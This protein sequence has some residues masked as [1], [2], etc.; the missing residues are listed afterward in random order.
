MSFSVMQEGGYGLTGAELRRGGRPPDT[1][2]FATHRKERCDAEDRAE[3]RAAS[4]Q[5]IKR[6]CSR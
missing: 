1:V 3:V 2:D 6:T 5:R 4:A